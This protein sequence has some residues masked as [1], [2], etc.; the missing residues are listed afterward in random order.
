MKKALIVSLAINFIIAIFFIG[1]RYY[2]SYGAGSSMSSGS[3]YD[4]WN[5]MRS[6]VYDILPIDS[7][8]IVFIGNSH[9]EC[10]PVAEIFGSD[11]KNRGIGGNQTEHILHRLPEIV[12][13]RPR[14]IFIEAGV[15]DIVIGYNAEKAIDNYKQIVATIK[16]ASPITTIYIQSIFP[17]CLSYD[18]HNREIVSLNKRLHEFC[19]YNCVEYIDIYPHMVTGGKL[20]SALTY[21]GLH[22]NGKGYA[23]WYRAIKDY[24]Q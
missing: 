7:T 17:V 15:N 5:L 11:V 4:Q 19:K 13:K 22:L 3:Y 9:T 14:K 12:A 20:D 16:R 2:Y 8:D 1:K 23:I 18:K 6:S 10:F 24:V 21:D